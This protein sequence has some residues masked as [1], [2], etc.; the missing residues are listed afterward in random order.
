MK[1]LFEKHGWWVSIA[2]MAVG[3]GLAIISFIVKYSIKRVDSARATV[4][5]SLLEVRPL[6]R[7]TLDDLDNMCFLFHTYTS[8]KKDTITITYGTLQVTCNPK[9]NMIL[10]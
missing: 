10:K 5:T 3:F 8:G 7:E 2:L 1:Q 9:L 4:V 6:G